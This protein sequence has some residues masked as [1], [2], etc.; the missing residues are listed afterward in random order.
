MGKY[1]EEDVTWSSIEKDILYKTV[2]WSTD[3]NSIPM[4]AFMDENRS[5]IKIEI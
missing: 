1:S 3:K 2:T 4:Y 5:R